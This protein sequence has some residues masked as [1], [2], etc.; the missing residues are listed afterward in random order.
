MFNP[1]ELEGEVDHSFFDSDCE[2]SSTHRDG[3]KTM[4]KAVNP[5][6]NS[7]STH[8]RFHIKQTDETKK[9]HVQVV[10]NKDVHSQSPVESEE[11][12]SPPS[13]KHPILKSKNK[14]SPKKLRGSGHTRSPSPAS[15]GSSVDAD[16]ERSCSSNNERSS[17]ASP[18]FPKCNK[19]SLT[20]RE[21]MVRVGSAGSRDMAT[22]RSVDSE[23]TATDVS[24]LSSPDISPLQSVDLNHREASD[25]S[26]KEQERESVPSSGLSN[27]HHE[28][29]DQDVD[30]LSHR[31]D[32]QLG[33]KLPFH[34]PGRRNRKNYSF[35]NDE[36]CRI[37]RENQR[38]LRELSRL[39]PGPR[40]GSVARKKANMA[41]TS[42][43][44]RISHSALNRQREQQRI[45]RENL[46]F[47]KR[48][49]SVKPTPGL[50]RS[51]QLANY[52][53]QVGYLGA[54]SYPIY[55]STSKKERPA[56]RISS[57][58]RP[59]SSTHL[60]SRAVSVSADSSITP[61]SRSE[62]LNAA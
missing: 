18:T 47:L 39:S 58:P 15:S 11:E 34:C 9:Q 36:V 50:R 17:L 38:L 28:E 26:P 6:K 27:T 62:K 41:N 56:S 12:A 52:Q 22:S 3:G 2:D 46:A 16:S 29:S 32:S 35:S 54:P 59:T 1:S 44:I 8:E 43:S 14:H 53:R 23:D 57:G 31:S 5:E 42:P 60:S 49:E 51:E 37:D 13:L 7:L 33:G 19:S 40:P 55:R 25:R 4:E 48:L 24:P 30:E 21:T 45:E 20:S 61:A 10:Y